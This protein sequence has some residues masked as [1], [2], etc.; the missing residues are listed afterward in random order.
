[1]KFLRYGGRG[2]EKPGFLDQNGQ[3]RDLSVII[4]DLS[5]SV[6]SHLDCLR[7]I[8]G[9][10][11]PLVDSTCRL[12]APVNGVGKF[13]CVGLNYADH[14]A[15]SGLDVPQEP[16]LFMK[17]TSAVCGPND[18]IVIPLN[19]SKTD[20]EV[21]LA[22][23]IGRAA[24]HVSE[25]EALNH[26]AGYAVTNDVSEREFQIERQ[27]QWTKGK[28]CDNFGQLGPWLVT[29]D[30][31]PDPQSL[32]LWLKVNGQTYQDGSSRTMVYGV[33]FLVSY[34][35][36]FMTLEPGDIISTGTPPGVGLG[37]RPPKFLKPGD[38]VELGIDGLGQQRQEVVS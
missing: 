26:V 18:P 11:L 12:G 15:E 13:I 14:A 16:V 37:Q 35:S 24:K 5:G 3:I 29:P 10:S 6:L 30:E 31:I 21:E 38:V 8:D 19:S 9:S 36:Q 2:E 32:N 33:A 28:S 23:V 4:G 25:K 22:V 1:M 34:I 27:G 20:W 7:G 17:A